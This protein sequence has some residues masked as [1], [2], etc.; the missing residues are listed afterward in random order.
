MEVVLIEGLR[1][2]LE[3]YTIKKQD[4]TRQDLM[5]GARQ[6][7]RW[8]WGWGGGKPREA[9]DWTTILG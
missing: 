3:G 6:S 1:K 2:A 7:K 5:R 4:K 9:R 8:W